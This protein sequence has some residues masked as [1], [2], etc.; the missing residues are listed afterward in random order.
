[1]LIK[2]RMVSPVLTVDPKTSVHDALAMMRARRIRRLPVLQRGRLVGIVTWTDVMRAS[3]SHATS[4]AAWEIPKLLMQE[5]VADIMTRELITLAPTAT[6][7]HAAVLM[8]RHKIGGLPVTENAKLVGIITES[9]VFD[10]FIDLMGLRRGGARLTID[11]PDR[12]G[13]LDDVVHTMHECNVLIRSLAAYPVDGTTQ[14]VV[15]VDT[16]YPLHVVQTLIERG[17][18]VIHLAPLPVEPSQE[19]AS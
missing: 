3:P 7:E 2:D 16:P 9:D 19:Q 4:L 14:M 6:I 13:A 5:Q 18:N 10:A 8:R 1:M 17:I 15:R 11:L 12:V